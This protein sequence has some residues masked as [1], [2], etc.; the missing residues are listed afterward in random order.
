MPGHFGSAQIPQQFQHQ[1]HQHFQQNIPGFIPGR[2][3]T[4]IPTHVPHHHQNIPFGG[5]VYQQQQVHIP[6]QNLV[7]QV[8][9][10]EELRRE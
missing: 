7:S 9:Q 2:V 6:Q 10:E 1:T 5:S 4:Q 8:D 3:P